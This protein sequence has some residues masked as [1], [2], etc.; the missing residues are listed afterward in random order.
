MSL[1]TVAADLR[2]MSDAELAALYDADESAVAA[3]LAECARRDRID[4][5]ARER[6]QVRAAWHDAAHAAYL[7]AEADCCGELV[8]RAGVAAGVR[9]G[10][11]LW[12]GPQHF[13]MA[14]AT[15]ELREWWD[16]HGRLTIGTYRRQ[17]AADMRAAR[18]EALSAEAD[19]ADAGDFTTDDFTTITGT[20][21]HANDQHAENR[22]AVDG[23]AQA[24]HGRV[25]TADPVRADRDGQ[26]HARAEAGRVRHAGPVQP[27]RR[28]MR[29]FADVA[30]R[31]TML[32][33]RRPYLVYG[34]VALI[35]GAGSLGKG[36]AVWSIV[37]AVTNGQPVGLDATTDDDAGDVIVILPEDKTEESAVRRLVAS[38]AN[39]DR[40]W[41]MTRL[42][43]GVRFKLSASDKSTGHL[44]ELRAA[45]EQ[46]RASGGNPRLVVIDPI[47][48]CIGEGTIQTSKG[49][50]LFV[51]RLQDF[52]EQAGVAVLLVAHPVGSGK[53]QGNHALEQALRMVYHVTRD[54]T[55]ASLRVW[56][57]A[58]ANDLPPHL[59]DPIRFT[60]TAGPD[61]PRA[62][63]V[64]TETDAPARVQTRTDWRDELAA[65]RAAR[66]ARTV[67][68]APITP[69][70]ARE[71]GC[72]HSRTRFGTPAQCGDC[73]AARLSGTVRPSA[74][75]P[76]PGT[77]PQPAITW[78]ATVATARGTRTLAKDMTDPKFALELCAATPEA[79]ALGLA[80]VRLD[81]IQKN[82]T[83]W[84]AG[85]RGVAFVITA[86][87]A[88]RAA[89]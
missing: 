68:A 49:A 83:T 54:S 58:K 44:P 80:G 86:Q 65:R 39:P 71:A 11:A 2:A 76:K 34:D 64:T 63:W 43:G 60:I 79:K 5:A 50:R 4:Q 6:D 24:G 61:G 1:A 45:V 36:R 51:E 84:T 48:A 26:Q 74:P 33:A 85:T 30:P 42:P 14:Y 47:G 20:E 8:N 53:L 57:V 38:G 75:Q 73:P 46:L 35:Y 19:A 55:D 89:G 28:V 88:G 62:E 77:A 12:S 32:L 10:F 15:D 3:V 87:Q 23:P 9:D 81:W 7:Q 16:S 31:E 40:V 27:G 21:G 41:D 59:A 17:H 18:L 66:A 82:A 22:A 29:S 72:R 70:Q 56:S 69:Q 13:A 52:A 67:P 78:T 25:G 37:A